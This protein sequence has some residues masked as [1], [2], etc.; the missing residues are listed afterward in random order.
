MDK[1]KY[2]FEHQKLAID[3]LYN[4]YNSRSNNI[5]FIEMPT[6][7]G[8]TFTIMHYLSNLFTKEITPILWIAHSK[9]LLN[10]ARD[11]YLE[12]TNGNPNYGWIQGKIFNINGEIIFSSLQ[13]LA[14][15]ERTKLKKLF[16]KNTP[17]LVVVDEFHRSAAN[18]WKK[19]IE[20]IEKKHLK[21]KI[22]G[23]S[24][25]PT[26][27][28]KKSRKWLIKH[29]SSPIFR[30]GLTE[31]VEDE[32]LAKPKIYRE[33][34]KN[35][36]LK[37]TNDEINHFKQFKDVSPKLLSRLGK[38]AL[39]NDQIVKYYK[40][41]GD[42]K[43]TLIF[44]CNVKHADKLAKIFK[45]EN[46]SVESVHGS[47][48]G[49]SNIEA[50][51]NFGKGNLQIITSVNLLNEGIDL[52]NCDSVFIARPTKSEILLKQMMGRAMRGPKTGGTKY[53]KIIDFVDVFKN[54]EEVAASSQSWTT[55]YIEA[56]EKEVKEFRKLNILRIKPI[57]GNNNGRKLSIF[58]A[59]QD[60]VMKYYMNI[61]DVG[62]I[63][64]EEIQGVLWY[65]DNL[66]NINRAIVIP[67][68]EVGNFKSVI[69]DFDKE[70]KNKKISSKIEAAELARISYFKYFPEGSNYITEENTVR[71]VR[72]GITSEEG[73]GTFEIYNGNEI[74]EIIDIKHE[75][76]SIDEL[77]KKLNEL[78]L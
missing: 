46:V 47:A 42:L 55:G 49:E 67:K 57:H 19:V 14:N 26:R 16:K 7:S 45:K 39:R 5:G 1:I 21:T 20:Y 66:N 25:T 70:F 61:Y 40:N 76:N 65:F 12:E 32:I 30:I 33:V 34:I 74:N 62:E 54:F 58:L 9:F 29:Y 73:S 48:S 35:V 8:K 10:Q 18:T 37:W 60:Y 2:P 68:S 50:L 59:I 51:E 23:I 52:P 64:S 17:K 44:C 22:V 36:K 24:A 69:N 27:T 28:E 43:Q 72:E 41:N 78:L 15:K 38:Q 6:G 71:I 77:N 63:I 53:C 11:S 56:N 3:N 75:H 4:W 13:T 31:L